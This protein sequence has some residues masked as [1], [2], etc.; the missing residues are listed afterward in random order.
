M[1]TTTTPATAPITIPV[2]IKTLDTDAADQPRVS[3]TIV[4]GWPVAPGLAVHV[5]VDDDGQRLDG[6]Y[7]LVHLP[8]G[9]A[10][11]QRLCARH[12]DEAAATAITTGIDWNDDDAQILADARTAPL[13]PGNTTWHWC[14]HDDSCRPEAY[15]RPDSTLYD[16]T[17]R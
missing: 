11:A 5:T 2:R 7:S 8:S 6:R 3:E 12:V 17:S 10:L 4:A 1:T 15:P 9:L 16:P 14:G 13:R